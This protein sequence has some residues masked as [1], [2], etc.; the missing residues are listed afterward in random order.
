[1][2]ARYLGLTSEQL[3]EAHAY[4][5]CIIQDMG[6]YGLPNHSASFRSG[7]LALDRPHER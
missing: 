5:G 1:M 7:C 4:G 6:Y 2:L 3:K